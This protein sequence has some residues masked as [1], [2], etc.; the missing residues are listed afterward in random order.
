MRCLKPLVKEGQRFGCGKCWPCRVNNRRMWTHRILLESTLQPLNSWLTLTYNDE[1]LPKDKNLNPQEFSQFIKNLRK[2]ASDLNIRFYGVGEYGEQCSICGLNKYACYKSKCPKFIP[3][4][5]RPHYHIVLFGYP[6]CNIATLNRHS[7]KN[8]NC[9]PCKTISRSWSSKTGEKGKFLN[10]ELNRKTAEYTAQYVTKK[11]NSNREKV[12]QSLTPEFVR[13]SNRPGIG[14]GAITTIAHGLRNNE[15]LMMHIKQ[16][17]D[18]P[19]T[20]RHMGKSWPLDRYLKQKF[21]EALGMDKACP[22][23]T[24]KRLAERDSM[25]V[26]NAVD[27]YG[28][29]AGKRLQEEKQQKM[30]SFKQRENFRKGKT[31]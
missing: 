8:C 6:S 16:H 15:W 14:A 4:P 23:Q 5:G 20:L 29:M 2:N 30:Y 28:Y 12:L 25:E 22:E 31:L 21:R 17:G 27:K 11:L 24:I 9:R 13:M 26:I 18:V 3:A 7:S 19:D 10:A 1:H